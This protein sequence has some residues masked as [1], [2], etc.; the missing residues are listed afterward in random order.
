MHECVCEGSASEIERWRERV[1][2]REK[3]SVWKRKREGEAE[4][5]ERD[6]REKE[7]G[8]QLGRIASLSNKMDRERWRVFSYRDAP[9]HV[10]W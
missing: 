3:E 1:R 5:G 6:E 8:R 9:V 2:K 10:L 4:G 7:T